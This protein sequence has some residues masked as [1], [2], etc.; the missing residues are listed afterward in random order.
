MFAMQQNI[1]FLIFFCFSILNNTFL[2]FITFFWKYILGLLSLNIFEL[3]RV[4]SLKH[5]VKLTG[6]Q[7]KLS[8]NIPSLMYFWSNPSM[9][10]HKLV[11]GAHT[12]RNLDS[13]QLSPEGEVNSGG[14]IPRCEASRYIS[15]A[16]HRP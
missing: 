14:Y 4:H 15:T 8:R 1:L 3:V 9:P 16:L 10:G 2:I 7:F 5:S 11:R 12:V 13:I 6:S